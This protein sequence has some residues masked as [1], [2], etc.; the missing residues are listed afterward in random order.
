MTECPQCHEKKFI[1][2]TW[3]HSREEQGANILTTRIS[4]H[5]NKCGHDWREDEKQWDNR[6]GKRV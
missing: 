1:K 3:S 6:T 4:H 5:C 2:S